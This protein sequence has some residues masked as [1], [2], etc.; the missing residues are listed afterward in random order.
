[1]PNRNRSQIIELSGTDVHEDVHAVERLKLM[2]QLR[3]IFHDQFFCES[4]TD[5]PLKKYR[6]VDDLVA[7]WATAVKESFETLKEYFDIKRIRTR[8]KGMEIL[9]NFFGIHVA[10]VA[11]QEELSVE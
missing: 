5:Y 4:K 9:Y 8:K 1:M 3:G 6:L 10:N 11:Y 7:E 2:E